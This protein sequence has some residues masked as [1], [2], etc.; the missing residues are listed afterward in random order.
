MNILTWNNIFFNNWSLFNRNISTYR[1]VIAIVAEETIF[2]NFSYT[3]MLCHV[4]LTWDNKSPH[5]YLSWPQ[6]NT[7]RKYELSSR[8]WMAILTSN[9]NI[10][11]S[12]VSAANPCTYVFCSAFNQYFCFR[13]VW[14]IALSIPRASQVSMFSGDRFRKVWL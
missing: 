1:M 10:I 13:Y 2:I 5:C 7:R 12:T 11:N 8:E 4:Y 3:D 14:L 9:R 6:I